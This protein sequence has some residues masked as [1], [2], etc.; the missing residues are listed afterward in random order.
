MSKICKST[1][2]KCQEKTSVIKLRKNFQ[3]VHHPLELE[4]DMDLFFCSR[5]EVIE[6]LQAYIEQSKG[7]SILVTGYRGVGKTSLIN[8]VILELNK[9]SSTKQ[10][11]KY[12]KI[13]INLAQSIEPRMLMYHIIHQIKLHIIEDK[14]IDEEI[15]KMIEQV[16]QKTI[17][18]II[19]EKIHKGGGGFTGNISLGFVTT[20]LEGGKEGETKTISEAFTYEYNDAQE[21][22]KKIIKKISTNTNRKL[23]FVFDELDKLKVSDG[24]AVKAEQKRKSELEKTVSTLKPLFTETNAMFIFVAGRDVDDNWLEDQS[25]G[26]GLYESIFTQNVYVPSFLH[27]KIETKG[28]DKEANETDDLISDQTK[29]LVNNL[30]DMDDKNEK[31][32]EDNIIQ[33]F[34]DEFCRYLTFKGRGIPRK[35]LREISNFVRW[36]EGVAELYFTSKDKKRIKFYSQLLECIE[37]NMEQFKYSDD[38]TKVSMFYIL[39]Y[40]L[41]FYESGF[42]WS[43][44]ER[45]PIL[46]E[47]EELFLPREI[48]QKILTILEGN[49]IEKMI[50]AKRT[51]KFSP[52]AEA[53]IRTLANMLDEEQIEFR[54]TYNDFS[55]AIKYYSELDEKLEQTEPQQ[56]TTSI[57]VQMNLGDI[58]DKLKNYTQS[59]LYYKKAV[60]LGLE[61]MKKYLDP[62]STAASLITPNINILVNLISQSYNVIGHIHEKQM[63][64]ATA[65]MCYNQALSLQ[66]RSWEYSMDINKGHSFLHIMPE[67]VPENP[68]INSK[69]DESRKAI[70]IENIV[71]NAELA[72]TLNHIAYVWEKN[73]DTEK[74]DLYFNLVCGV[75]KSDNDY[76]N[77]AAQL[78]RIG[79]VYFIRGE[80][81]KAKEMYIA[82]D[83]L[84]KT[85][86]G[87]PSLT[88]ANSYSALGDIYLAEGSVKEKEKEHIN[89][90]NKALALYQRVHSHNDIITILIKKGKM[91]YQQK[92]NKSEFGK[93]FEMYLRALC[94]CREI[95]IDE[96]DQKDQKDQKKMNF[97]DERNYAI[98][99]LELGN[100]FLKRI[101][102]KSP[103]G[104]NHLLNRLKEE[105]KIYIDSI[106]HINDGLISRNPIATVSNGTTEATLTNIFELAE[107]CLLIAGRTLMRHAYDLDN[108]W[109]ARKLG[110]L[111]YAYY[112]YKE[113]NCSKE[114]IMENT[115]KFFKIANELYAININV[116]PFLNWAYADNCFDLA[117]S[118]FKSKNNKQ[119]YKKY[120]KKALELYLDEINSLVLP[121]KRILKDKYYVRDDFNNSEEHGDIAIFYWIR[122]ERYGEYR[123]KE[124]MKK[125]DDLSKEVRKYLIDFEIKIN[126]EN[127][128]EE[129]QHFI[130]NSLKNITLY[131]IQ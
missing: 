58:Y 35:I 116:N 105:I 113:N 50:G 12:I 68:I 83:T 95:W 4:E 62:N 43:D 84:S 71:H 13:Y 20:S 120:Y 24:D 72:H 42:D 65:L 34:Y 60:R 59:I 124:E 74:A 123:E 114:E 101:K 33:N 128:I 126:T 66:M 27:R 125:L 30:I 76:I 108:A 63:E 7:G 96:K 52:K 118:Y 22:I 77:L 107:I 69:L 81:G 51:Y 55:K 112:N 39:D 89:P 86:K 127:G 32:E 97:T 80:I 17:S 70:V 6:E 129:I 40:I 10:I 49:Y 106:A 93:D 131:A 78:S 2:V 102:N 56:R 1:E 79:D 92:E 18:T 121:T 29:D 15:K 16:Y 38:R 91:R 75:L 119:L 3:Y 111:Y 23:I 109:S 46:T 19:T 85:H 61:E 122:K 41:K 82:V 130:R 8:K 14:N 117:N 57:R 36:K 44:I 104:E 28:K 98:C 88:L 110:L 53:E 90:Y 48:V 9:K 94:Q 5:K 11:E 37:R 87:I 103:E 45:A 100:L 73:G 64:Y 115:I 26:D 25:K 54:F 99:M 47:E 21:D 31:V 67:F